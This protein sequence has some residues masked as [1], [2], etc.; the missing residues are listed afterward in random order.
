MA[1]NLALDDGLIEEARQLGGLR[2]KK[3]VVTQALL[4]YIQR[5]KQIK[6]VGVLG[7][8]LITFG[9]LILLFLVWQLWFNNVVSSATQQSVAEDL[10][11]AWR[12]LDT[13]SAAPTRVASPQEPVVMSD[14]APNKAFANLIVPRLGADYSRPIAEGVDT[15][16]LNST[17]LGMGHYS[18]TQLPGEVGNFA[19]ASHRSAFGGAF[20]DLNKLIVGD[21]I[22]VETKDGWYRYVFRGLEY[23]RPSGIGVILPVPQN[24]AVEPTERLITLTTC[25]PVYST[26]ER[27]I[28]YG[29]FD[30]WYPRD[31]GAPPEIADV[32]NAAG[33]G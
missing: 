15:T 2:T 33:G 11:T 16:V 20:H 31:A 30:S 10:S 24:D 18:D 25:N 29:M 17:R 9:V 27:M 3:D 23:V 19:L 6:L 22:Y 1:T 32:V 21:S 7:E 4:E 26:S 14:P 8:I 28:A 5:R 13:P 12:D